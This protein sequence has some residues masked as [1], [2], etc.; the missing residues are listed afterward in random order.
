MNNNDIIE[1][2][3][4]IRGNLTVEG[5]AALS[6][7]LDEIDDAAIER[8]NGICLQGT[9]VGREHVEMAISETKKTA[10]E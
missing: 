3:L 2:V 7:R 4:R 8:L 5:F 6:E 1:L 9:D 10:R